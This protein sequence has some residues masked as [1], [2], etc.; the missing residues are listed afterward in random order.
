MLINGRTEIIAHIGYPTHT[1]TS[2]MIY[3]PY[4]ADAGINAVVVP[5]GSK[6]EDYAEFLPAVFKLSNII[7]SLI[8]M[9]HK[10]TTAQMLGVDRITKTAQIAGAV[11]AVRLGKDGKL[12]GD[13][14]DGEGFVRGIKNKGFEPKGK[15]AMVV[16]NGGVGSAIA[17][18]LA[19]AG[20][21]RL[22]LFD[23]NEESSRKLGA[24]LQE[25]YPNLQLEYA[26]NDPTGFDLLVN[27]TPMGMKEGDP[28]PVDLDKVSSQTFVGDVVLKSEPT[29][30]LQACQAKGCTIQVGVDILFEQIPV[31]LEYFNLPTTT[32]QRLRE[33]ADIRY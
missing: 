14:F 7:G 30:F 20:I 25:H 18:S 22:A 29:A 5:M 32:A 16:G 6:A 1:F 21:A 9:S 8:T 12:E 33:L 11:N 19:A 28:M 24:R 23:V 10:V 26:S 4:F 2:P 17:A 27:A 15:S 31:Y 13:L 3:N